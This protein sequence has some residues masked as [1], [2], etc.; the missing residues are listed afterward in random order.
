MQL[1]S[2]FKELSLHPKNA[3]ELKSLV[4]ELAIRGELTEDFSINRQSTRK[5][6]VDGYF[7]LPNDWYWDS[8]D[9]L[10]EF[11]M[12]KTPPSKDP[13]Y[14]DGRHPW[15]SIADM[16][17]Y[18]TITTTKKT[19]SDKGLNHSFKDGLVKKGTLIMSFKLS[20]GKTSILGIDA[21][22]NEA[23]IS[24]YPSNSILKEFLFLFLPI[25]SH[26]GV[27]VNALMGKTLNK[28]K[29]QEMNIPVP[30]LE[31]QKAIVQVVNQ[32]FAE[33]EQLEALTKKRITLKEDFVTSALRRLTETDNTAT[34]WNWLKDQF[35]T[36]FTEKS[37][38]KKLREAILQLAVQGKL[39]AKWRL[40]NP[41]VEPASELLKRIEAEKQQLIKEKKIKKEAPLPPV[42]ED[43]IPYELPEGWVW[44]RM[45]DIGIINPRNTIDDNTDIG[46]IPMKSISQTF[47]ITPEYEVK[48]WKD[49]KSSFTHFRNEDVAFAK[50]TPCFENSK[51]CV[52]ND[53]PNGHGAG[54]TELHVFRKYNNDIF[55]HFIY[56]I[57]KSPSFLNE[58]EGKMTGSA[59]Q[60]RVPKTYFSEYVLGLPPIVE[61]KAIVEK[62]N[63][64]MAL[65]DEL[66]KQIETS[67]KQVEQLMQSCLKEVFE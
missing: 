4:L 50:I 38:V 61:Q 37:S 41:E 58:G 60:K 9:N 46:F 31:E 63:T 3:R 28:G 67:H 26:W 59:G 32:L 49:V 47:S 15:I 40:V 53:L 11:Q 16:N 14:W 8:F 43:E 24:I 29:I 45:I 44:C 18:S 35:S 51:A 25:I 48:K 34:E 39:T 23:I 12:G 1:L 54:T 21:C 5:S 66:E 55:P 36:F 65:C 2:L 42:K 20:I 19:L 27:Q 52:F 62:V 6:N 56:S 57:F 17:T 10:C 64:L 7:K 33:V 22:H 30:P 13:Q